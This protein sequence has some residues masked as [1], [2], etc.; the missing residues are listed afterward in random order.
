MKI[1]VTSKG[2][3]LHSPVDSRFG[4]CAYFIVIDT[5]SMACETVKNP[6]ITV[7]SGAGIQSAQMI[8]ERGV[9]TLLTGNCGP[10]SF[11]ILRVAGVHVIVEVSGLVKDVVERFKRGDFLAHQNRMWPATLVWG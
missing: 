2:T 11:Q 4:R 1:A 8:V 10:N 3:N 5:D 9:Q 7:G 6:N